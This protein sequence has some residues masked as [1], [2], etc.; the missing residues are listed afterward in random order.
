MYLTALMNK[1]TI[2][3]MRMTIKLTMTMYFKSTAK[4]AQKCSAG[5]QTV[6]LFTM[7]HGNG[8]ALKSSFSTIYLSQVSDQWR[9]LAESWVVLFSIRNFTVI[10]NHLKKMHADSFDKNMFY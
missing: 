4:Y 9:F 1:R 3:P 8:Q 5:R 6:T 10:H 2:I 7:V